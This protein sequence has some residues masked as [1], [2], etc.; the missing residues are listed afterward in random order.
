MIEL[1]RLFPCL[2]SPEDSTELSDE[3]PLSKPPG[4]KSNEDTLPA[5]RRKSVSQQNGATQMGSRTDG[6]PGRKGK[7]GS[8]AR[9][10][11][12]TSLAQPTKPI[13]KGKR[14]LR[15]SSPEPTLDDRVTVSLDVRVTIEP[16]THMSLPKRLSQANHRGNLP[17]LPQILA[18]LLLSLWSVILPAIMLSMSLKVL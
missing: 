3:I 1:N 5:R 15:L 12:K 6:D 2:T 7:R 17:R 13:L 10:A 4:L 14:R 8:G 9:E 18:L 11:S 16:Q